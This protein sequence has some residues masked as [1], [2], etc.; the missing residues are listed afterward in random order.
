MT[1]ASGQRSVALREEKA[2]LDYYGIM[3]NSWKANDK[4]M[5]TDARQGVGFNIY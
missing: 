5:V 4:T 2:N 1:T 3:Y